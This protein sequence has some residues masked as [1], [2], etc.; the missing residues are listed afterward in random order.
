[1]KKY[2]WLA[3]GTA[4][5]MGTIVWA[6]GFLHPAPTAV[7]TMQLEPVSI[8]RT[9]MCSGR[10]RTGDTDQ[11]YMKWP[12]VAQTVHVK[13]GDTVKAGDVLFTVDAEATL[14]TLASAGQSVDH[15]DV[16]SFDTDVTAPISGVVDSINVE[17]GKAV[18]SAKPCAVISS[19]EKLRLLVEIGE[20][21]VKY[22]HRGQTVHISGAAFT[23]E[24]YAGRVLS[25]SSTA[26]EQY[27]GTSAETVVEATVE[28]DPAD[29]DESLRLGLTATADIVV[30]RQENGLV[31]PYDCVLQDANGQEYVY[32]YENGYAS[33]RIIETGWEL[34]DGFQVVSGLAAGDQLITEPAL[35]TENGASVQARE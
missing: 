9:V 11:V 13:K 28:I 19:D 16:S 17:E 21:D 25:V 15:L 7:S 33:K 1:M 8:E 30:D 14:E 10:V 3:V 35:I 34:R 18:S 32:I 31:V 12:C 5:V 2:V 27:S 26:T 23:K 20:R 4:F 6:N 24:R 22:V 29:C